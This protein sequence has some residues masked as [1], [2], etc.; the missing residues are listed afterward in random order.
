[1][2]FDVITPW[3]KS[4]C[5]RVH[6]RKPEDVGEVVAP[7]TTHFPAKPSGQEEVRTEQAGAGVE[8]AFGM[9]KLRRG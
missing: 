9:R 4:V 6:G 3:S 7:D 2:V 1:M 8:A 5:V